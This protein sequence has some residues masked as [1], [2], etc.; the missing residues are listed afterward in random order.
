MSKIN[1]LSTDNVD[2]LNSRFSR[3]L[4]FG[5][6]QSEGINAIN[7]RVLASDCK[8]VSI[9]NV[10]YDFLSNNTEHTI[11]IDY[12][13]VQNE[14]NNP[15][16]DANKTMLEG[17]FGITIDVINYSS[18][19]VADHLKDLPDTG[20]MA[21]NSVGSMS[22][23]IPTVISTLPT[24][25]QGKIE[26]LVTGRKNKSHTIDL[27]YIRTYHSDIFEYFYNYHVARDYSTL[28][29]IRPILD[30]YDAHM[31]E[32]LNSHLYISEVGSALH[33][34]I[35]VAFSPEV[36][37]HFSALDFLPV[38]LDPFTLVVHGESVTQ[39]L[40]DSYST[41]DIQHIID[42]EAENSRSFFV[43]SEYSRL[44]NMNVTLTSMV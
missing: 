2:L 4:Q 27:D 8:S 3:E 24:H 31:D 38:L 6:P 19:D 1:F 15:E 32:Y 18:L 20:A 29:N 33:R 30:D 36:S 12:V 9:G 22:A 10:L 11:T 43:D 7:L 37:E 44:I 23:I 25:T 39:A 5:R 34:A 17:M 28:F 26:L 42:W 13:M 21:H 41:E 35:G 40:V 16:H 14:L